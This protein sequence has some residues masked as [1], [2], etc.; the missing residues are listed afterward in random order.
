MR[1]QDDIV[2]LDLRCGGGATGLNADRPIVIDGGLCKQWALSALSQSL[3]NLM[4]TG[5][6]QQQVGSKGIRA[7]FNQVR[8]FAVTADTSGGVAIEEYM[9]VFVG[10]REIPPQQVIRAIGDD[11]RSSLGIKHRESGDIL[12]KVD[13]GRPY[14]VLLEQFRD[15]SVLD[16]NGPALM[17]TVTMLSVIGISLAM[18]R[19]RACLPGMYP[20]AYLNRH[21]LAGLAGVR[22]L[23]RMI[24]A[25]LR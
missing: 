17:V 14:A 12:W 25:R 13:E 11:K 24:R 22:R 4:D 18:T 5:L 19:Q 9:G 7:D 15:I 21:A 16:S 6:G 2:R 23:V 20:L 3:Q 10:K 8:S 1:K